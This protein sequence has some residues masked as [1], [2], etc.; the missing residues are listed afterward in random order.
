MMLMHHNDAARK[1]A[2]GTADGSPD[3]RVGRFTQALMDEA[4][5]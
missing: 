2:D 5:A 1:Y 3:A 4:K